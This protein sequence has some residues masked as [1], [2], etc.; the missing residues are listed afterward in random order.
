MAERAFT[1]GSD[2]SRTRKL[3]KPIVGTDGEI[4]SVVLRKPKY[5]EIM[6]FGDP[7]SLLVMDGAVLP[8]EDM[9]VVEKY[10]NVLSG[11]QNGTKIIPDL[12]NQVDY[13]DAL[14]LKDAVLSFFL[15]AEVTTT[16]ADAPKN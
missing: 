8:H 1:I 11:D 10:M 12:L 6:Q 14:A 15:K 5:R 2:G 13:I 7:S 3:I 4:T 16:S 9:G